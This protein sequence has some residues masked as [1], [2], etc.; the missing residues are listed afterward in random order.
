[1]PMGRGLG[2]SE[3]RNSIRQGRFV[4]LLG[5]EDIDKTTVVIADGYDADVRLIAALVHALKAR[6]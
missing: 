4:L 2:V 1:M 6:R 3:I 5:T